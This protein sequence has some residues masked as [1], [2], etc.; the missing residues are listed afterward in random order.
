MSE[1]PVLIL[2]TTPVD[3]TPYSDVMFGTP[4][5]GQATVRVLTAIAQTDVVRQMVRK[6]LDDWEEARDIL[7]N[8]PTDG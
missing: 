4:D 2:S 5:H 7:N 3:G 1:Y 8:P 6:I